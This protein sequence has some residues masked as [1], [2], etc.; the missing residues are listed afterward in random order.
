MTEALRC[1]AMVLSPVNLLALPVLGALND[2]SGL[3]VVLLLLPPGGRL[4]NLDRLLP[5]LARLLHVLRLLC[6]QAW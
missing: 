3:L 6:I 2:V 4:R 1:N 5:S